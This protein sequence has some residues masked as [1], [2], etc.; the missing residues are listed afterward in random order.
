MAEIEQH[1]APT[2]ANNIRLLLQQTDSRFSGTVEVG[3][4]RGE[5]ASIVDQVGP[6][7]MHESNVRYGDIQRDEAAMDRRWV[8]PRPFELAQWADT[9]DELR[10]VNDPMSAYVRTAAAAV[11]R[12]RDRVIADAFFGTAM[13]GK[14]A[15]SNTVSFDANNVVAVDHGDSGTPGGLTKEKIIEGLRMFMSYNA[16][17][18]VDPTGSMDSVYLGLTSVQWSDLMGDSTM[19]S[20]DYRTTMPID[21]GVIGRPLG[22]TLIHWEELGVDSNGYRELPMWVRSGVHLG[23]WQDLYTDITRIKTK[24]RHPYQ[25]YHSTIIGSTRTEEAKVLKVLCAEA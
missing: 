11:N 12:T 19:L 5:Q 21:S 24:S 7:E 23:I 14:T 13:T 22:V 2:Y 9:Y 15:A 8:S 3:S 20:S 17:S 1:F 25:I 10:V 4:H 18:M 16:L 6:L